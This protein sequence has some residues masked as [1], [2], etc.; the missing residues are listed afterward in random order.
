MG[1]LLNPVVAVLLLSQASAPTPKQVL[2]EV[3]T[4]IRK[5]STRIERTVALFTLGQ[6]QNRIGDH[7]AAEKS[8]LLG[9][10][11]F[12][13]RPLKGVPDLDVFSIQPLFDTGDL[14]LLPENFAFEFVAAGDPANARKAAL[15]LGNSPFGD[16]YR[17]DLRQK[18]RV[19]YPAVA[20]EVTFT[21]AQLAS[22]LARKQELMASLPNLRA[23]KDIAERVAVLAQVADDLTRAGGDAEA[24]ALCRETA[25]LAEQ[26]PDVAWRTIQEAQL[27]FQL[28][29]LGAKEDANRLISA[30][31]YDLPAVTDAGERTKARF[32][33]EQSKRAMGMP[34]D[35]D[36]VLAEISGGK[37]PE[38]KRASEP[39]PLQEGQNPVGAAALV[40][41]A[42]WLRAKGDLGAA[43]KT[44][45]RVKPASGDDG[46]WLVLA[47]KAQTELGD[48]AAGRK[49][50]REGSRRFVSGLHSFPHVDPELMMRVNMLAE[51]QKAN[52]DK[53]GVLKTLT[54]AT[55]RLSAG[56]RWIK[57]D[58]LSPDGNSVTKLDR[59]SPILHVG[60]EDLARAGWYAPA[61]EM[62]RT[63]PDP[64]HRAIALSGIVRDTAP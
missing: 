2:G 49:N 50:L 35:F 18:L 27:A 13:K 47:G 52:G 7:A 60:A 29:S 6:A 17:E 4:L 59:K 3:Q 39:P 64:A 34:N 10:T 56:E 61:I 36:K 44:L 16:S 31:A 43:K 54:D 30:A 5:L 37:P 21:D 53:Y 9:W 58:R 42:E 23:T 57:M 15:A 33:I 14:A 12:T 25:S 62:A 45:A 11:V 8:L 63:I 51:W 40:G 22:R 38:E 48:V 20:D 24:L 32:S 46:W 26:I 19:K 1:P 41:R 55:A 28:W